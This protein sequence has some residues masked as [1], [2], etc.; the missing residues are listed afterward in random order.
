MEKLWEILNIPLHAL[1]YVLI[2]KYYHPSW[3]STPT[4]GGGTNRKTL[5]DQEI[6]FGYMKALDK[7]FPDEEE[8][9]MPWKQ[10]SNYI[11]GIGVFGTNH[12]IKDR[13]NL[14][15]L[16]WWNMHGGATPLLLFLE[17]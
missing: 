16:D 6:L 8:W 15:S 1:T 3:I 5:Q 14:S 10:L 12:A 13:G 17:I 11:L 2:P 7:L 9:D 4:P